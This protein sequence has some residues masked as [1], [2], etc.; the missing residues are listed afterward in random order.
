M[1]GALVRIEPR[2][3]PR[4]IAP[5]GADAAERFVA[6]AREDAAAAKVTNARFV[7]G[8]IETASLGGPLRSRVL[9]VR[10]DV[11]PIP[12]RRD[13][14]FQSIVIGRSSAS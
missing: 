11:S 9:A 10:D 2:G 4:E 1:R 8:D 7:V 6:A 12:R 14:S 3:R 5:L 13:R